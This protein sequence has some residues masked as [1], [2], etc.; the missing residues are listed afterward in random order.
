M[1]IEGLS[2]DI[3]AS[4]DDL[5]NNL[6]YEIT[7]EDIEPSELKKVVKGKVD[8][9]NSGKS[10][11]QKWMDSPNAPTTKTIVKYVKRFILGGSRAM[12]MMRQ[13]LSKEFNYYEL[14]QHKH[15]DIAS[16][17]PFIL[18]S[19]MNLNSYIIELESMIES[20]EINLKE[21]EFK[22]GYPE[23]FARG[24][25]ID[26]SKL[27]KDWYNKKEDAIKICP[28]GTE[29]DIITLQGLKIQL[30]KVPP[31]REILFSDKPVKEQYWRRTPLPKGC[32]EDNEEAFADYI[33]EEYRR[34]VYGVWFMNKGYPVYL[35][36][37]M[38]FWLQW[39]KDVDSGSYSNFRYA[40]CKLSYHTKAC[41]VDKRCL[42]QVFIKS[43]RT[44]FTLEK[45]ARKLNIETMTANHTSGM[46]SKTETDVKAAFNKKQYA[47]GNLPFF[48]RPV[49][50][51]REDSN[52]RIE[53]SKPSNATKKAKKEKVNDLSDYLN[54][55]SDI[56]TTTEG[57]YDGVKLNDYLADEAFKWGAGKNFLLHWGKVAP[58][59][60]ENG[61]IVGKAW[62]GSTV[63]NEGEGG[64]AASPLWVSSNPEERNEI[65]GRTNSGLYRYFM[66]I[67]ENS[68]AH[69]DVYGICHKE[70]PPKNTYCIATKEPI[71]IGANKYYESVIQNKKR[72]G[73][74]VLY[75]Y[76][77]NHPMKIEH[78]LRSS[79]ANS[80]LNVEN[81][82][83]Q[84]DYLF[85]FRTSNGNNS[86]VSRGNLY[87]K[88]GSPEDPVEF[89]P[90]ETGRFIFSWIPPKDLRNK[91]KRVYGQEGPA[92]EWLGV[93]GLDPFG[94]S[95]TT[96]GRGSKGSI[97]FIGKENMLYPSVAN[98]I[99]MEY[100]H[101]PDSIEEF[102][103]DALMAAEFLG[104]PIFHERDKNEIEGYF[105]RKRRW[106]FLMDC[107]EAYKSNSNQRRRQKGAN[108]RT[109]LNLSIYY[110]LQSYINQYVGY[111]DE[112]KVQE[113]VLFERTLEDWKQFEPSNR[114]KYDAS[115]SSGFAIA[116]AKAPAKKQKEQKLNLQRPPVRTYKRQ[117]NKTVP[118][119][120][121]K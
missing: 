19:I 45:L 25:I 9:F 80:A 68:A 112:N 24:E 22:V 86:K 115:I 55:L 95:Q 59:M 29:G 111:D 88:G 74:D 60:D 11:L 64:E 117:G 20:D 103:E 44:G 40:Q 3:K 71:K 99:I 109:K 106:E 37:H 105:E 48:F 35:T 13:A 116:A 89:A 96:D 5:I 15:A 66:P 70:K 102:F 83:D 33:K 47:F 93:G 72:E 21:K 41:E 18:E 14:E 32:T 69:T 43:R 108:S 46:T 1:A 82:S 119:D 62:I 50:K 26:T 30:P 58:T 113:K 63:G 34:R 73:Q 100:I 98:K 65:T 91:K 42:G 120:W 38:Y 118:I 27:H 114:T 36:G 110:A 12:V 7:L 4:V 104:M 23:R 84:L 2:K 87:R 107:P 78:A 10:I 61:Y 16:A 54:T 53:Y 6:E 101:R 8:S 90:D 121:K 81:I 79:N 56:R 49:V 76:L 31:K 97:H 77:R 51:G 94:T 75:N 39:Y 92:N 28:D 67:Q 85:G 57:A 52:I 17:K